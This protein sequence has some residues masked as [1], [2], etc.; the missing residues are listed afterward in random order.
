MVAAR[1]CLAAALTFAAGGLR[2]A[3]VV[4]AVPL[5][6]QPY[7]LPFADSGLAYD[8]IRA[9]FA[10]RGHTVRPFYV[11]GRSLSSLISDDSR[12]DCIPMLRPGIEHGWHRTRRTRLLH[13]F[14]IT[15]SGV[16]LSRM[17]DLKTR[18]ILAYPGATGYLG[19]RFRAAVRDNPNYREIYNHRAQVLLLLQGS[20]EVII[21][22]RILTAWYLNYLRKED[23][24][25][26]DVV[27]HDL[28]EPVAHDF[29]CRR[30]ELAA[31][32]NAG[33]AEIAASGALDEILRRYGVAYADPVLDPPLD[34]SGE[35][36]RTNSPTHGS[37]SAPP[38]GS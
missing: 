26:A 1:C 9:A 13:D 25:N 19:E 16:Q 32:Y 24:R 34:D 7:F 11:S 4:I 20:V 5:S 36:D 17:E 37:A 15:R 18:R 23:G 2:A 27:F 21:A 29:V 28:F 22:D 35:P 10:A 3:E 14:A 8:T 33:L 6:L 12:A 38:G 31:E 30:A